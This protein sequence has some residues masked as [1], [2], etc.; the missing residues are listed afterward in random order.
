MVHAIGHPTRPHPDANRIAGI[1]IAIAFNATLLF[2]L[3]V[4]I[5]APPPIAIDEPVIYPDF[6]E[7]KK[8]DPP[9]PIPVPVTQPQTSRPQ[10]T[11]RPQ[12]VTQ[13]PV[14]QVV[15]DQG[16]L[17]A[18][19][20][21]QTPVATAPTEVSANTGPLPGVRLEYAIA[22]PPPYPRD[23]LR[24]GLQGTVLLQV[25]VDTDGRPL[26][27]QIQRSSGHRQLDDAARRHVLR[28][29]TFRPA[30][31]DGRALQ[32]IGLVPIAFN[33]DR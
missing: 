32:A 28:H 1:S 20:P 12:P 9:P 17:P 14:Q 22:P 7:L 16:S 31:R 2:L 29:W 4:P 27:V 26:D 10:V 3:L 33:L 15:V 30:M 25:L 5:S 13:P 19:P 21:I 23:A 11:T 6:R 18:D 24:E 8:P